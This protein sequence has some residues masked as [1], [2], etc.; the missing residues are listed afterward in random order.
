MANWYLDNAAT[1]SNNGTSWANAWQTFAAITWGGA[2]VVAGDTLY[3]SGGTVSKTYSNTQLIVGASGSIGNPITIRVGQDAGHNGVATINCSGLDEVGCLKFPAS[4]SYVTV[5]GEYGGECHIRLTGGQY[6]GLYVLNGCRS[7]LFHYLE[8]DNNGIVAH[9][10]S[11]HG[12]HFDMAV[13]EGDYFI[14]EVSYCKIHDNYSQG[15]YI[16]GPCDTGTAYG[17]FLIHHNKIY[18]L[19]NDG[20]HS[21]AGGM[22]VYENELYGLMSV[23][24][25][26]DGFQLR[27]GYTRVW[28]NYLHDICTAEFTPNSYIFINIGDNAYCDAGAGHI[29]VWNNIC[30]QNQGPINGTDYV[31]G[32]A[33]TMESAQTSTTAILFA[34]N[35][36]YGMPA[37][38]MTIDFKRAPVTDCHVLNNIVKNC[39]MLAGCDALS[40]EY[41]AGDT[42]GSY[43]DSVDI[44]LDYNRVFAGEDGNDDWAPITD[45]QDHGATTDPVFTTGFKL[46][47]GSPA[48]DAAVVLSSDYIL[49]KNGVN[50]GASWDQGAYEYKPST[51][52]GFSSALN[53]A[54]RKHKELFRKGRR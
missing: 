42:V 44:V 19:N 40:V 34:N 18:N 16:V 47:A 39:G 31:R 13:I 11:A 33:F 9:V 35:T 2:G 32:I 4:R 24:G 17:R 37:W 26:P 27:N 20:I 21:T 38:G 51:G 36:V 5:N 15:M 43:G 8:V 48:R 30:E 6:S 12:I 52:G 45:T 29:A 23:T 49:D 1:G 50:R 3:I 46:T 7:L 10:N 25:H 41:Y 53:A 22:D 28:N 14:S 54:V